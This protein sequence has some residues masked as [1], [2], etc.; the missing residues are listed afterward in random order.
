MEGYGDATYGDRIASIYDDLYQG[1]FDVEAQVAFLA[2]LAAGGRVLELAIGTGR[3]AVPLRAT[4]LEV[5]GIDASAAMVERLRAHAGEDDI[6]VVMGNFADV[7]VDGDFDLI[8]VVFNTLF[9]LT[10][11][12]E[13]V[14]CF[15]NVARHLTDD[16]VFVV[17][18]FVPDLTR[19]RRHQNLEVD[20]IELDSARLSVERHDP[21]RQRVDVQHVVIEDGKVDLY[22]VSLRYAYPSELDLMAR[23]ADL[24]LYERYGGWQKEPF[25]SDSTFHVSVYEKAG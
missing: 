20:R 1:L 24:R 21:V 12:E 9:A 6:P 5:L 23:L 13:Q 14:R 10:T 18:A 7:D 2:N 3:V 17:E 11:Q 25:T 16:G 4:G 15:R 19:F 22:P 8:Y